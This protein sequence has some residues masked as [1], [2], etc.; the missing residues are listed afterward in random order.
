MFIIIL[1]IIFLL[2]HSEFHAGTASKGKSSQAN[3]IIAIPLHTKRINCNGMSLHVAS[4]FASKQL[5]GSNWE[6]DHANGF[7][8]LFLS[9]KKYLRLS[10]LFKDQPIGSM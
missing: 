5:S 7:S 3:S 2:S 10:S 4:C 8:V 1:P 6:V 9:E